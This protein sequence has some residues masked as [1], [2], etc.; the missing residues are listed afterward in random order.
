LCRACRKG[1]CGWRV[2]Q[3]GQNSILFAQSHKELSR[4]RRGDS[5]ER[6]RCGRG[7]E[8]KGNRQEPDSRQAG[9]GNW[10]RPQQLKNPLTKSGRPG[11]NLN[12]A[13]NVFAPF[14]GYRSGRLRL[15]TFFERIRFHFISSKKGRSRSRSSWARVAMLPLYDVAGAH[16]CLAKRL[17]APRPSPCAG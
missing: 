11:A 17:G 1:G 12:R 8:F 5:R 3:L 15:E 10:G 16:D 14:G 4:R 6:L 2:D 7:G 9:P 13:Q